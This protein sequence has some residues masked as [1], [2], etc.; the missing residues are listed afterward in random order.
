M[1]LFKLILKQTQ[2]KLNPWHELSKQPRPPLG[3]IRT[4]RDALRMTSRQLAQRLKI[5]QSQVIKIEQREKEGKITLATLKRVADALDCDLVYCL[6][7]RTTLVK[8]IEKQATKFAKKQMQDTNHTMML[9]QQQISQKKQKE[10][11]EEIIQDI[12]SHPP[13]N[14]W[15]D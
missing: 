2:D 10:L 12:I 5:D 15:D 3:W 6:V 14:L 7:P 1:A 8:M 9:E 4:L 13:R 11:L